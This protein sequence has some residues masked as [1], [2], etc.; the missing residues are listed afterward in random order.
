MRVAVL[1]SGSVGNCTYVEVGRTRVL[2]DAGLAPGELVRRLAKV[3]HG[4]SLDQIDAVLLTHEHSDHVSAAPALAARGL[5]L[6][7]TEGTRVQLGIVESEVVVPGTAF[8]I[9]ELSVTPVGIPH[10]AAEPV[11][12]VLEGE[13]LRVGYLTDCGHTSP[14][15]SEAFADLHL[16]VLE[17][18]HDERLLRSGPYPPS[19]KRR[20]GSRLGHLSNDQAASLL[21]GLR[22][23]RPRAL[24]LAH[25]SR[26]NNRPRLARSAAVDAT[27]HAIPIEVAPQGQISSV[28][29]LSPRGVAFDGHMAGEQLALFP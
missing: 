19:L 26:V 5:R 3:P 24:M 17:A 11:G 29:T 13:G 6:Y 23:G 7:M 1:A 27:G 15:I 12:Y 16:F 9:G 14:E 18:N 8:N 28:A 10:D 2:V 20:I 4:A 25:L 21:R 22:G